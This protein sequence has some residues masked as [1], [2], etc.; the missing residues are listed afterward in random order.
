M[1]QMRMKR[2]ATSAHLRSDTLLQG[3]WLLAAR[4][5]WVILALAIVVL[6]V[7]SVPAVIASTF[8]TP[9]ISGELHTLGLSQTLYL[10]LVVGMN[11]MCIICY[12]AMAALLFWR[13]SGDRMAFFGS[14]T[15]LTFGGVVDGFP[16]NV[17]G[18]SLAWNLV[19]FVPFLLGQ[20]SFLAFFFLFP[21]GRFVP[22]W[23]GWFTLLCVPYWFVMFFFPALT[24]G[25]LGFLVIPFLLTAVIAQ[26]YRYRRVSTFRERQQTKWV[27][28]GFVLAILCFILSRLLVFVLPPTVLNSQVAGNLLGG[29]SACLALMLI[30]IF[31][32]I[33]ILRDRLF[34]IDLII[35]RTLVYGLLTSILVTLYVGLTIGL[36]SL[37]GLIAR[38]T[39][40]P[41]SIVLST[42]VI[43]A[44]FQPL[45]HRVQNVI[46]RRFYRRKYDAQKTLAAFASTLHNEV[47]VQ[48]LSEHV[49]AVV[50]E[51]M[52][53]AH[54][55]LW[56]C[57]TK[58]GI[59]QWRSI[60]SAS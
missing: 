37:V 59:E 26:V 56:L 55:S 34:D 4:L 6:N 41:V 18:A 1:N 51:T 29:G 33:A 5:F 57:A 49:L 31:L 15:L 32:G 38:Q 28:F 53:P 50:N 52:Q 58:P 13:R 16:S 54:I 47:D 48:E 3:R 27:V 17:S 11:G 25:P 9:E 60:T 36:E 23:T 40:Q 24:A 39:S 44:I 10:T 45:R 30:P 2:K 7:L 43:A 12:L 22:R 14:L 46:D 19:I 20:V 35:N 21:S 8:L 42:L